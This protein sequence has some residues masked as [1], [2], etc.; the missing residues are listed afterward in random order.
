MRERQTDGGA[1]SIPL[2]TSHLAATAQVS[3]EVDNAFL[4]Y[5]T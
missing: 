5:T 3:Q 4:S 1:A 2:I